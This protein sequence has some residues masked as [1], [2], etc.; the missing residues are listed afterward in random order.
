MTV[1]LLATILGTDDATQNVPINFGTGNPA[2]DCTAVVY[3]PY[4]ALANGANNIVLPISPTTIIWI[5]NIDAAKTI[6]VVQT[7]NGGVLS[8]ECTLNSG[9]QYCLFAN[10]ASGTTPGITTLTLT[11]SAAGALVTY[12]LAG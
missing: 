10:P 9:E 5:K 1:S 12:L 6:V 11:A 8:T 2:F 4:L 7:P 3:E